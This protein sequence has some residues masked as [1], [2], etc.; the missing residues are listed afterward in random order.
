METL[1]PVAAERRIGV[2]LS[3]GRGEPVVQADAERVNQVLMNLIG[4]AIKFT[5]PG[6]RVRVTVTVVEPAWAQVSVS[7]T[8]PGIPEEEHER[9]FD[10]FYQIAEPGS[11]RPKGTGLG[12][13]ISRALVER[14]GGRLWLTSRV[15]AG[16]TFSFTLPLD[17]GE[18]G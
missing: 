8:G 1:V 9:V 15:G 14:H 6:G 12:L 4:N 2:E 11:P 18:A 5:P 13:A 3:P 17:Q 10:K 7:D 16:S